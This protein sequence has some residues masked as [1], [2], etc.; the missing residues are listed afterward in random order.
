MNPKYDS[1]VPEKEV[2]TVDSNVPKEVWVIAEHQKE[3]LKRRFPSYECRI[4][5]WPNG[6]LRF[7]V[8]NKGNIA[9]LVAVFSSSRVRIMI[10]PFIQRDKY[11]LPNFC[12][13]YAD[14]EWAEVVHYADPKFTDDALSDMLEELV[15]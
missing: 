1:H 14:N 4:Y 15:R 6:W 5:E 13:G 12:K 7:E 10:P 3:M 9:M 8:W 11:L 2:W